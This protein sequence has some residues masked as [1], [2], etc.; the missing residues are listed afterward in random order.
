MPHARAMIEDRSKKDA[1]LSLFSFL[2]ID[3]FSFLSESN[4]TALLTP[5]QS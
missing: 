3:A 2:Q 1:S 5:A 4:L